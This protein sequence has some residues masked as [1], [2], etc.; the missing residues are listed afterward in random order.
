MI[1]QEVLELNALTFLHNCVIIRAIISKFLDLV[2][3]ILDYEVIHG[4]TVQKL[5]KT[6]VTE[7]KP[8]I[9]RV[10]IVAQ[11]LRTQD[12]VSED[13]S[14]IPGVTQWVKDPALP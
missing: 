3:F 1:G 4:S 13:A 8:K 5:N 6:E 9:L 10:P 2:F 14:S 12:S 11:W 7:K